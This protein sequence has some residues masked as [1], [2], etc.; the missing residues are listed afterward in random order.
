MNDKIE[1]RKNEKNKIKSNS[2]KIKEL[3]IKKKSFSNFSKFIFIL[4][5]QKKF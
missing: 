2:E 3:I 5:S 1:I 4:L